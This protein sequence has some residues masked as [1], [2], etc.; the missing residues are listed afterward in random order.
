MAEAVLSL[1][2]VHNLYEYPMPRLSA[3]LRL[4]PL[5]LSFSACVDA[6]G[7]SADPRI[8]RDGNPYAEKLFLPPFDVPD[9]AYP[10][11]GVTYATAQTF[12]PLQVEY[13]A[14]DGRAWLWYR[15]SDRALPGEWKLEN[16]G[17]DLCFRYGTDTRDG[18]T[19]ARGGSWRCDEQ[20]RARQQV[21]SFVEGDPFNLSRGKIPQM[22]LRRCQLPPPMQQMT[23]VM[24]CL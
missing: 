24:D 8:S 19:G 4:I 16:D 9:P 7:I 15:G 3:A 13:F 2:P 5:C 17:V 20:W 18:L 1:T 11:A 6:A 23:H 22:E 10:R 21:V 14:P 12:Y